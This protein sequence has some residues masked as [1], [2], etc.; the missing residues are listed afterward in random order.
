MP[1]PFANNGHRS[2]A[3]DEVA[4]SGRRQFHRKADV[5]GD[6][7]ILAAVLGRRKRDAQIV[8]FPGQRRLLQQLFRRVTVAFRAADFLAWAQEVGVRRCGGRVKP[9]CGDNL[10]QALLRLIPLVGGKL[11]PDLL[12]RWTR[13]PSSCPWLFTR[14]TPRSG[15]PRSGST[16]HARPA[17]S[18][19]QSPSPTS[20]ANPARQSPG[21]WSAHPARA[22][23]AR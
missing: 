9:D 19:Q 3:V 13:W 8:L 18:P 22:G 5:L 16:D 15:L 2:L 20:P 11:L 6:N 17:K 1:E 10:L 12:F 7:Q 4:S 21:N 14:S 23:L